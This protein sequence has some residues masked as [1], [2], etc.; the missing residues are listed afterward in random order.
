MVLKALAGKIDQAEDVIQL[1]THSWL[2]A[3]YDPGDTLR[4]CPWEDEFQKLSQALQFQTDDA[5]ELR[6]DLEEQVLSEMT[7]I[8]PRQAVRF[9][10]L[11]GT[12]HADHQL[13]H[14]A[15]EAFFL[16]ERHMC[17]TDKA[18][19]II[20]CTALADTARQVSLPAT[21]NLYYSLV[22]T[23]LSAD[24]WEEV[25]PWTR[26]ARATLADHILRRRSQLDLH[27]T[28]RVCGISA[29]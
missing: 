17:A 6:R 28:D 12:F 4:N 21:A 5:D 1:A 3:L 24:D 11:I 7:I 14:D 25:A 13:Y 20:V 26:E 27:A 2:A 8:S 10:F 18:A 22:L 29:P 23:M 19:Y 16:C 9:W 15:F